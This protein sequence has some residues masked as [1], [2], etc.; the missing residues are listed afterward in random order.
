MGVAHAQQLTTGQE[1]QGMTINI[2]QVL[3]AQETLA[4]LSRQALAP[5]K[6]D[7]AKTELGALL[8]VTR[9]YLAE[10]SLYLSMGMESSDA[11][12]VAAQGRVPLT[13]AQRAL[14]DTL[15]AQG[16]VDN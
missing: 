8:A 13:G 16:N 4:W 2:D 3:A 15:M 10:Y 5:G 9:F 14:V 12:R 1:D 7:A 6:T 11:L